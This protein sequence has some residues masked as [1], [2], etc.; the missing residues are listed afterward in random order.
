MRLELIHEQTMGFEGTLGLQYT[1]KEFSAVGEEAFIDPVDTSSVAAFW[2]GERSFDGFDLETGVRF[3]SVEHDPINERKR[4]F[5]LFSASLGFVIPMGSGWQLGLQSDY[6]QRAPVPEELYSNG[7]HLATQAFEIGDPNLDKEKAWNASATLNYSADGVRFDASVYYTTFSDYIY[8][9]VNG[10]EDEESELPEFEYAQDDAD[11]IGLELGA[12]V[13]VASFADGELWLTG[14]LDHVDADLDTIGNDNVPRLPPTRVGVGAEL[15]WRNVTARIDYL[16]VDSQNDV[17]DFELP[18]DSYED[19]RI[20][21]G[22]SIAFDFAEVELFLQG[23]NLTD[24]EQRYHTSFIKD[25]ASQ[26]GRSIEGGI[27]MTF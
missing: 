23:K 6:S 22:T 9:F 27:R 24:D 16:H 15:T 17:T 4:D 2:V 10:E 12:G 1:D 7:A 3:E 8:E 25:V 21:V 18:T 13:R 20:F 14:M 5:S 19:L 11:F 26:P